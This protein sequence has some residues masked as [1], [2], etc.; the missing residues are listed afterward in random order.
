MNLMEIIHQRGFIRYIKKVNRTLKKL[1]KIKKEMKKKNTTQLYSLNALSEIPV[2][3]IS[4]SEA[5][6]HAHERGRRLSH[7]YVINIYTCKLYLELI[8]LI[9]WKPDIM[10]EIDY[11]MF[12]AF[13][14]R[15]CRLY[16]LF[17]AISLNH[18]WDL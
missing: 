18:L 2:F 14:E 6:R 1:V 3:E 4:Q 15:M 16:N 17:I 7:D 10:L 8:A 11:L 5:N 12:Q 13:R 9:Q